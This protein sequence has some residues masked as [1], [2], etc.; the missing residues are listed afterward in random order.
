MKDARIL[1]VDDEPEVLEILRSALEEQGYD[2]VTTESAIEAESLITSPT[3]DLALL[4]VG[5][6]GL[7]LGRK[8]M[9][10]GKPFILM[11]GMPVVIEM[12]ELGAVLRKPFR[13]AEVVRIIER[14]LE[15]S[16]REARVGVRYGVAGA[17]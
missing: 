16:R 5:M 10:A 13:L 9:S 4:D 14:G 3:V 8:A 17:A 6:H 7:R 12:G 11:S 2:V 1:V 15:R